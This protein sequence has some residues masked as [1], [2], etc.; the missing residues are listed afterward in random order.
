M[1][2]KIINLGIRFFIEVCSLIAI[3]SLGFR[4]GKEFLMKIVLSIGIPV[5][6][7]FLWGMFASPAAILPA[8]KPFRVMLE[9]I[10]LF[11]AFVGIYTGGHKYTAIGFGIVV[12]INRILMVIWKQ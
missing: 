10:I 12:V 8:S 2:I 9:F 7:A 6:F 4:L 11:L 1:E 3:G 5:V